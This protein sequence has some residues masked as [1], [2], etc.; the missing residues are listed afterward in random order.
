MPDPNSPKNYLL[1]GNSSYANRGCEAIVLGTVDILTQATNIPSVF[2]NAFYGDEDA[3]R[4]Q[5]S[6]EQDHRISHLRLD[7]YPRKWTRPWAEARLN[8]KLGF[9]LPSVHLPLEKPAVAACCALEIGGDNYTL[10]YVFPAHLIAM[11]RW[12]MRRK[13]PVVIW[14]ASVGPFSENPGQ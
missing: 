2:T 3:A 7:A 12:L 9:D 11:D 13:K 8:E 1:V 6:A 5:S 10:D 4:D 14:G